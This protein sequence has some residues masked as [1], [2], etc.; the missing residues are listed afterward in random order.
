MFKLVEKYANKEQ[1]EWGPL[2]H[3]ILQSRINDWYRRSKVRNRVW[4]W[5]GS[6]Y[7]ED[8]AEDPLQQVKDEAVRSP[9][10]SLQTSQ[11][12]DR[13]EQALRGLPLRQQQAFLLRVWEGLDVKQT[14]AAMGCAQGSVKAHY[15]RAVHT[16]REK[17]GDY[18]G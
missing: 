14:A 12:M 7:D 1:D 15:S 3:R 16:L 9:E 13:L 5:L 11:S 2:F 10:F 4:S 6:G 18:W 17:L 8:G